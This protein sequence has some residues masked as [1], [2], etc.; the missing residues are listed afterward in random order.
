MAIARRLAA[1]LTLAVLIAGATFGPGSRASAQAALPY[2]AYGVGL[3]RGQVV[4]ALAHGTAVGRATADGAGRWK[5]TIEPGPVANG[6]EMTFTVDGVETG[7]TVEFHAGRF[8]AP[9]GIALAAAKV[10]SGGPTATAAPAATA[11]AAAQPRPTATPKPKA[12]CTKNGRPVVCASA[13][14]GPI[15]R[16]PA[17]P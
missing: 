2:V 7:K 1:G 8:P 13:S 16:T 10:V 9:P 4:E 17:R 6:D 12:A 5:M 14:I 15:G 3:E 11:K